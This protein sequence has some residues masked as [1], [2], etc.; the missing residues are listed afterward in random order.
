MLC[1]S[2][3]VKEMGERDSAEDC[4]LRLL[5]I[6]LGEVSNQH[7]GMCWMKA[8]GREYTLQEVFEEHWDFVVV[9]V[10]NDVTSARR[11]SESNVRMSLCTRKLT[12]QTTDLGI[13][14]RVG[15]KR[16]RPCSSAVS[17]VTRSSS[18]RC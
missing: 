17:K 16:R 8:G 13:N 7:V 6:Q 9:C 15:E 5:A 2:E 12:C 1:C 18:G 14:I 11:G 4:G 3:Y 10:G